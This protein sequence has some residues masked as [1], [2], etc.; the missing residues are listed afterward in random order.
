[1]FDKKELVVISSNNYNRAWLKCPLAPGVFRAVVK[2]GASS[3]TLWLALIICC[4]RF[5]VA[6]CRSYL[7]F[8]VRSTWR[9]G[10]EQY[11]AMAG[12]TFLT[13]TWLLSV[14]DDFAPLGTFGSIC[15]HFWLSC[16]GRGSCHCHL[17]LQARDAAKHLQCPRL[18]HSKEIASTECQWVLMLGNCHSQELCQVHMQ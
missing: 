6:V 13:L 8:Q 12:L 18:P 1:M 11:L 15:G 4:C 9:T 14:R 7:P 5:P 10:Q 16:W 2:G 3:G 17:A